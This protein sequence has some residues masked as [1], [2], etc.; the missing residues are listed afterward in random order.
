MSFQQFQYSSYLILNQVFIRKELLALK[1]D[2]ILSLRKFDHWFQLW[3]WVERNR[4]RYWYY[5]HLNFCK[6][7]KNHDYN[8]LTFALP[9]QFRNAM[10]IYEMKMRMKI[11]ITRS[12][13]I[14]LL[15]HLILLP[16]DP[17]SKIQKVTKKVYYL[18]I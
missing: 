10:G 16:Q 11:F 2:K 4:C 9:N 13:I 18:K 6:L 8:S 3:F 15:A 12:E 1:N 5:Y 17:T 7:N 14:I